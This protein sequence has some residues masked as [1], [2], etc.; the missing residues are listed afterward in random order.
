MGAMITL[1]DNAFSPFARK[2]R[3]A[4]GWKGVEH[5][6]VDGLAVVNRDRLAA[7]NGRVEVPVLD[8]DGVVVVGSADIVAYLERVWPE[9]ALY[10]A[11]HGAWVH[12][13]A[14][15]RCADTLIDPILTNVSYW[16]WALREDGLPDE[17]LAAAR[18]DLEGV[19]AALERDL[20]GGDFVSGAALSV[21]DVALFP[22]LT[23]T[24]GVGVGYDAGRFPRLHGWLKRLR[25]IEVFADDLRRTAGFVAELPHSTGYER[26]KIFWRGDRIE[27][28][29]ACGQHDW[30]MREIAADRVL[31]PG[32]GI[33]GPGIPG[34]RGATTERG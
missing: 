14:W 34:P 27:W 8:H 5:E 25:V 17:V 4:L 2:V 15:E 31:W 33:P 26:R 13:R 21:A 10:P 22:H 6:V 16:R 29:L 7:V 23:A 30:L 32:P 19:Y 3:L 1:Y 9:P 20:G 18:R 12:A 11:E 28:M 24:R